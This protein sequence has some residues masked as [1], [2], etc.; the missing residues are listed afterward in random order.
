MTDGYGMTEIFPVAGLVCSQR[1]LHFAADQ[2]LI[3]V[4]DPVTFAPAEPGAVGT[5]V[6]TPFL[7]YRETT[8]LLRLDTGDLV[9]RLD[10]QPTC[11][12]AGQ[13]ATSPVLGR[14][15]LNA[16][17]DD[18]PLY[19]RD[20][21]E[22]L[23]AERALPLPARYG[24]EAADDGVALHVLGPADD[25]ELVT[26]L[27]EQAASRGLPVRKIV[28]SPDISEIDRPQFVRALLRE[29]VVVREE[30]AGT[31]TLR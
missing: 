16:R 7:P 25:P 3:E 10:E 24:V 15:A 6:V 11:E 19:Q 22:L 9:R 21:L 29:T 26:R 8:L 23:E 17:D 13:P 20:I 2:G 27:E 28:L 30:G 1:H 14:E 4:L 31:W 5:L 12:L 18:R